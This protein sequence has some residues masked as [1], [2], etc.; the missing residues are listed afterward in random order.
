[1]YCSFILST[2][3]A[4]RKGFNLRQARTGTCIPMILHRTSALENAWMNCHLENQRRIYRRPEACTTK[5]VNKLKYINHSKNKYIQPSLSDTTALVTNSL[6]SVRSWVC[7]YFWHV[8]LFSLN[9]W[10]NCSLK[11]RSIWYTFL[12]ICHPKC[13]LFF[14]F[15]A[16]SDMLR[17][18]SSLMVIIYYYGNKPVNLCPLLWCR[19]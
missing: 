6:S 16:S 10:P 8:E 13:S 1:M 9:L 12:I 18:F 17:V 3:L 14:P 15:H 2:S 19:S 7:D 4:I 5:L 11:L